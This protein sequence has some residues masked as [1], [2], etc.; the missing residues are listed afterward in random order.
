LFAVQFGDDTFQLSPGFTLG[1]VTHV[2]VSRGYLDQPLG[3]GD[4]KMLGQ[5]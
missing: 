2:V 5:E 1:E 3:C 4:G